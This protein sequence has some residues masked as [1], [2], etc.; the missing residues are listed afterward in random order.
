LNIKGSFAEQE[1]V[2]DKINTILEEPKCAKQLKGTKQ[3]K[4]S[5]TVVKVTHVL[6]V[7]HC[8]I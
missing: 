6:G 8:L 1:F 3:T 7:V 4:K 5:N 2:A